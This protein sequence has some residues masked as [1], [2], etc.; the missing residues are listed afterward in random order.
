M[1]GEIVTNL[2]I[3]EDDDDDDDDIIRRP[4]TR[5]QSQP[6]PARRRPLQDL[7]SP[8][9]PSRRELQPSFQKEVIMGTC[10]P[11]SIATTATMQS[12]EEVLLVD[13]IRSTATTQVV[14]H[15]KG[16]QP[17]S[18]L[19]ASTLASAE[20]QLRRTEEELQK[21]K[22]NEAYQYLTRPPF[23]KQHR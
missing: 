8:L 11:E 5:Q 3:L 6:L 15:R 10:Y 13:E 9:S 4:M 17:T 12:E 23:P 19:L 7:P 22:E 21:R 16:G 1:K 20:K 2:V 14:S 18:V